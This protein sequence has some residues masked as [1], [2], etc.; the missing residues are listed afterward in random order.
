MM[1]DDIWQNRM[2]PI[3]PE[4]RT[5]VRF[6]SQDAGRSLLIYGWL[7]SLGMDEMYGKMSG[8]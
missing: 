7:Y 4:I 2:Q 3:L 8:W 1:A 5:V 6:P